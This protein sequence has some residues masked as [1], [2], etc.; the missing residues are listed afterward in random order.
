MAT[1]D[2]IL[3][4]LASLGA[5][6]RLGPYE[7]IVPIGRGGMAVVWAARRRGSHGFSKM[8][9]VKVMLPHASDPRFERMF[10]NEAK[11]A[12]RIHHANVC[13]IEDVGEADGVLY[14]VMEWIDGDSL[15]TLVANGGSPLSTMEVLHVASACARGLA[16]AHAAGGDAERPAGVV[17][18]DVSPQNI[19]VTPAGEVKIVD[20]GIAKAMLEGELTTES[21][22]IKGKAAYVAPEQVNGGAVDARTDVFALGVV[23]F[24][25]LTGRHPFRGSSDLATLLAIASTDPAPPLQLASDV[26]ARDAIERIVA[27]ALAKDPDDRYASMEELGRDVDEVIEGLGTSEVATRAREL[28]RSRLEPL[29]VLRADR[30]ARA[31][32]RAAEAASAREER[33]GPSEGQSL[34]P[35]TSNRRQ[36]AT[37]LPAILAGVVVVGAVVGLGASR[38]ASQGERAPGVGVEARE[39]PPR[40]LADPS[41]GTPSATPLLDAGPQLQAPAASAA[42]SASSPRRAAPAAP[43]RPAPTP[44]TSSSASPLR[45]IEPATVPAPS[46][47][48]PFREPGF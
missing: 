16:A 21:G 28:F 20:F 24:E 45:P 8:F 34:A 38:R 35:S 15:A 1:E 27:R 37:R 10:L 23:L 30:I 40:P 32:L 29:R 3:G 2:V 11:I 12:S 5:D 46:S 36:R 42:P 47:G 13:A 18:R 26:P 9:A 6:R 44:S 48:A 33:R 14:L 25:L 17:H 19:L 43:A 39:S 7:L 4:A 22:V 41:P 31:E